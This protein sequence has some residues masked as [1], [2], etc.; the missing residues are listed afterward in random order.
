M[1]AVAYGYEK[2]LSGTSFG[3]AKERV[4]KALANEGF[5]ILSEIDVQATLRKKL[6]IDFRPYVKVSERPARFIEWM[7]AATPEGR[8]ESADG[9]T[10]GGETDGKRTPLGVVHGFWESGEGGKFP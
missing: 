10:R 7:I 3:E 9:Q 4:V 8:P 1:Q 2:H 5:G 6:D